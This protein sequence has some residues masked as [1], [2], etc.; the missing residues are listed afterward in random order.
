[1][2]VRPLDRDRPIVLSEQNV[3]TKFDDAD[4][5]GR[6]LANFWQLRKILS[7]KRL[8]IDTKTCKSII[9]GTIRPIAAKVL[10]LVE[11][12][13]RSLSAVWDKT[14]WSPCFCGEFSE[15]VANFYPVII[16]TL[17]RKVVESFQDGASTLRL[18]N[19]L[20]SCYSVSK[21][22][23]LLKRC[24]EFPIHFAEIRPQRFCQ[25]FIHV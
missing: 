25:N 5:N 1:V 21:K 9:S 24:S 23:K 12:A 14:V 8:E 15:N 7:G 20:V 6:C 4:A 3:V 22:K 13:A 2:K 10:Q 16:W 19:F 17:P 11:V 18:L